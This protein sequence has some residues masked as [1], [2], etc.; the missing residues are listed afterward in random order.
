MKHILYPLVFSLSV[1]PNTE[2]NLELLN[3]IVQV[4][5][6]SVKNIK[7]GMDGF[8]SS[9]L[10][11]SQA[12]NGNNPGAQQNKSTGPAEAAEFKNGQITPENTSPSILMPNLK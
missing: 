8:H 6:D 2:K 1:L 11:F 5:Q 4:T 12:V 9:M 3:Y 7:A 10:M